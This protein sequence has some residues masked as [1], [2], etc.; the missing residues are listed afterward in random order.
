MADYILA[1]ASLGLFALA[2][3]GAWRYLGGPSVTARRA[4]GRLLVV[5]LISIAVVGPMV[6]ALTKS[7]DVQLAG[8]LI[9]R[10]DTQDK[11]V[12]LTFDDGPVPA[13]TGETLAVLKEY[14]AL[15]TFYLTGEDCAKNQS[16]VKMIADGGHEIGNHSY[17]HP[18]LFFMP[19]ERVAEEIERTDAAIRA[20]GY[21]GEITFRPPGCK[22][23][24]TTPLY[25]AATKRTTVTWDLEP[26]SIAGI[27]DD[28]DAIT[29]HVV[30]NVRP[31]SII[32]MHVMYDSREPS[33]K[34]LP[35]I[36]ERLSGQGYRFVTISDLRRPT[37]WSPTPTPTARKTRRRP[38]SSQRRPAEGGQLSIV[39][40][41]SVF[42][43]H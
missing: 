4:A 40:R 38:A 43:R 6:Y 39:T 12:A 25:L 23:L 27:Q 8:E 29:E 41:W 14:N 35:K 15:A 7:R 21:A 26:D 2:L 31:G 33:R 16:Q 37:T 36:L 20:A 34:A 32:L 1:L 9:S 30:E 17:S 22:R 28:A 24:L 10:I 42:D 18:R 19:R 13:H 11:V 5:S 3:L